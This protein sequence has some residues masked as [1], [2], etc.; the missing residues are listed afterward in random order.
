MPRLLL[1]I[2]TA[3][4]SVQASHNKFS[5]FFPYYGV[6]LRNEI[7][8]QLGF[9]SELL[10]VIEGKDCRAE[11]EAYANTASRIGAIDACY[12]G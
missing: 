9:S 5:D 4:I 3:A 10:K 2:L 7:E 11:H 1:F 6:V 8:G 12:V